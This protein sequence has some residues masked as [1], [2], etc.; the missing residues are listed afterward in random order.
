MK[1]IWEVLSNG[2]K[3]LLGWVTRKDSEELRTND[4]AIRESDDQDEAEK[5]VKEKDED[6]IRDLL[7]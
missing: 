3:L 6:K 7:S 2:M 1:G 4:K 5:A